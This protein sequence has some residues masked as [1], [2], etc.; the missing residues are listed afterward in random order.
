MKINFYFLVFV[1]LLFG[2]MSYATVKFDGNCFLIDGV[3][4]LQDAEDTLAYYYAP[5]YPTLALKNDSTAEFLFMKYA[6]V[7]DQTSGGLFHALIEFTISDQDLAAVLKKLRK[8]IPKA[9]LKGRLPFLPTN[10]TAGD[11]SGPTFEIV[12]SILAN[13][14]G[15]TRSVVTS[16][17]APMTAGS[18]A[19]VAAHL[20]AQGATLFWKSLTSGPTSDISIAVKAYYEAI[21]PSYNAV[22][23]VDMENV[24]SE[25]SNEQSTK[26]FFSQK[27]IRNKIDSISKKGGI[28]I[29]V[30]DRSQTFD[31]DNVDM[32][33]LVD[34]IC[35]KATDM[36]FGVAEG[37]APLEDDYIEEEYP[38]EVAAGAMGMDPMMMMMM[39]QGM[40]GSKP[41][42]PAMDDDDA[43]RAGAAANALDDDTDT[44]RTGTGSNTLDDD[45]DTKRRGAGQ[46]NTALDNKTKKNTTPAS[47]GT[48]SEN[49]KGATNKAITDKQNSALIDKEADANKAKA[50]ANKANTDKQNSALID[51][52]AAAKK[53]VD[54]NSSKGK[55]DKINSALIDKEAAAKKTADANSSKGKSDK[56]NSAL[57]DKEAAANKAKLNSNPNKAITDKQN[58]ALIDKEADANKA[59]ATANKANTDKQ[60]SALIDKEA[61]AKKAKA[62][63][64]KANPVKGNVNN[65]T[66]PNTSGQARP[67]TPAN[68][69]G[70]VPLK[71]AGSTVA[72][73]KPGIGG[74]GAMIGFMAANALIDKTLQNNKKTYVLNKK[75]EVKL[76]TYKVNLSKATTVKVPF[77]TSG[78]LS[79]FY[80]NNKNDDRYFNMVNMQDAAF[81]QREIAFQLDNEFADTYTELLNFVTIRF[82]KTYS[83]GQAD[84]ISQL[85]FSKADI[86]NGENIKSIIYPRLGE[87]GKGVQE[88]QY[89]I[90][91]SMKGKNVTIRIPENETEWLSSSDP[92][93]SIAPPFIRE[94][95]NIDAERDRFSN[96]GFNSVNIRFATVLG[97]KP[98]HVK[99]LVLKA[100][101]P[102]WN[103]TIS[104]Y[105]DV[106]QPVVYETTWYSN[107]GELKQPIQ[108]ID[109]NYL[110]LTPPQQENTESPIQN[111]PTQE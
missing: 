109:A 84:V 104:I 22:I 54:A 38:E 82:K 105:H 67:S 93:I 24:F 23:S 42:T 21:L 63:T 52:E 103:S 71:P 66:K 13:N 85:M 12:S 19:A 25:F 7:D 55:S 88:Y 29:E 90:I 6:G 4:L 45:T 15:I 107:T 79:F 11:F 5:K 61:D 41:P 47:S 53:P 34:L 64:N 94:E 100:N 28:K 1:F 108:A 35:A 95:I 65:T 8:K 17:Q 69:K 75:S 58:S 16:G 33:M 9:R 30:A 74:M 27:D 76:T 44:K 39:M 70:N 77:S 106:N 31:I 32:L 48:D 18:K 101:D 56:I 98:T 68:P 57:I 46:V 40:G 49:K 96:A 80:N 59:K 81:Q 14:G 50:T 51:K 72:P 97:G 91:W 86:A 60:N 83:N 102:E 2:R 62:T 20:D 78:N 89:Q 110:F 3:L 92:V 26:K 43:K 99:K 73:A 36:M 37:V 111:T 10:G 87:T